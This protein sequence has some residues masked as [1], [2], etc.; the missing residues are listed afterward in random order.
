MDVFFQKEINNNGYQ[1]RGLNY[2]SVMDYNGL[3]CLG[4]P[5]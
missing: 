3:F 4:S 1:F 2:T 5:L